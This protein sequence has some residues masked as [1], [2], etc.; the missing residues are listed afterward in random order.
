LQTFSVGTIAIVNDPTSG[1]FLFSQYVPAHTETGTFGTGT[2][3]VVEVDVPLA[4]I[5]VPPTATPPATGNTLGTTAGFSAEGQGPGQS[6]G[7]EFISDQDPSATGFGSDYVVGVGCASAVTPE[8]P[9][10]VLV[11]VTG[12]AAIAGVTVLRRRR[13]TAA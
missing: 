11:I 12:I 1:A 13:R 3:A 10:T 8:A 6:Q 4:D 7:N 9:V 2:N 5:A